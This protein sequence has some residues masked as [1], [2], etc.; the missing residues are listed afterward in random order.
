M[1]NELF[2]FYLKQGAGG[3]AVPHGLR[4]IVIALLSAEKEAV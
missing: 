1:M 4:I 2:V 3:G